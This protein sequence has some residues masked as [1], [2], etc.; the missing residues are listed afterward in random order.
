VV[1][2]KITLIFIVVNC[3]NLALNI[4]FVLRVDC[5]FNT[6]KQISYSLK[7]MNHV[8]NF[9]LYSAFSTLFRQ[10]FLSFFTFFS[11]AESRKRSSKLKAKRL[12]RSFAEIEFSIRPF[13][14]DTVKFRIESTN[15]TNILE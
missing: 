10:E 11:T 3:E 6:L 9:F 1:V 13:V 8:I 7:N 14:K 4:S 5:T 2:I 12:T 15:L